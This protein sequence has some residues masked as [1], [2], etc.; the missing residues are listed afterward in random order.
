[1]RQRVTQCGRPFHQRRTC[2]QRRTQRT[3]STFACSWAAPAKLP[4]LPES[5]PADAE[6]TAPR[7]ANA[8]TPPAASIATFMGRS[9]L[10]ANVEKRSHVNAETSQGLDFVPGV[11]S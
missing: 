1:L 10:D 8:M 11:I 5:D 3:S 6:G 2:Q 4:A 7:S 9:P